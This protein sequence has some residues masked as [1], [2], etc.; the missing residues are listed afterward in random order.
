M[1]KEESRQYIKEIINTGKA[2]EKITLFGFN[3]ED[4]DEKVYLKFEL[5]VKA[6]YIR[7]FKGQDAPFHKEMVM[8]FIQSYSGGNYVD[9]AFRGSSKTSLAKLFVVFVILNDTDH[10]RKYIKILSRDGKNSKQIVTDIYNMCLDVRNIYGDVFEKEGEKKREER[11]DSFTMK[12]GVK[13]TAGTVGQTQRGHIQD[14]YRPDWLWFEDIED[15]ESISSQAIT[16]SVIRLC[17]EAIM[18]LD[19]EGSWFVTGN[20]I[21]ENGTIQWFLDKKNKEFQIVPILDKDNKPTWSIYTPEQVEQIKQDAEDFFGEY[22]CDPSRSEGKF[23]DIDRIENDLKVCRKP[24]I[25]IDG[26]NYWNTYL[27]H[28]RY[29]IGADTGEGVGLDS[30]ALALFDFVTGELVATYHSNEIKPELFAYTIAKVG[31]EYGECVCAPEINNMS[32]GI[33]IVTLKNIYKNIF[34]DTDR[35]KIKEKESLKLGWHTNSRSKPQMFMDFRRDYNDGIVHIYDTQV[36]KEMKS[37]QN[38]DITERI[39]AGATTRHFDLLTAVVIAWQ[40][41]NN[42]TQLKTATV[43]VHDV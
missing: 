14:A 29:G 3:S 12:S 17:D 39:G 40:M 18:G 4:S 8:N 1:A 26:I 21:S 19:K 43:T 34:Q 10:F 38:I 22:M 25:V 24:Q 37:Y 36:L 28:H 32:G 9:L 15:R 30:S 7:F 42:L 27:M 6:N 35:T 5:F 33:V 20:Y 11:M 31:K 13:V 2:T 23:F 16:E 41:K